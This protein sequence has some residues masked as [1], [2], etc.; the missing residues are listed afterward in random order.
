M[1][2][3]VQAFG[4]SVVNPPAGFLSDQFIFHN[5][6]EDP[7]TNPVIEYLSRSNITN[8][9]PVLS[10]SEIVLLVKHLWAIKSHFYFTYYQQSAPSYTRFAMDVEF[11]FFGTPPVLCIKQARPYK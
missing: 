3:N 4:V 2:V 7:Y 5:M 9:K 8:G 1:T 11:K 10:D 6:T